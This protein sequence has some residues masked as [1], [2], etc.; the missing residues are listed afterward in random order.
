VIT[1]V[2]GGA[3]SGKSELAERLIL[4]HPGPLVYVAT[5]TAGDADMAARIEAHRQRRDAR[6]AVV[7]A[8]A[9][10]AGA[11]RSAPSRPLLVDAV[12]TWVAAHRDLDQVTGAPL[13]ELEAAL[14]A[15][16][17]PTVLVSDEVGW[18]VHPE[19][20]VGRRFRDVLGEVNQRL[21]AMAED[22]WLVV[23]GRV[24]RLDDPGVLLDGP[25]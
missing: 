25:G 8:G 4:R 24:V 10:L 16:S 5:G 6:F 18:G 22:A 11:L 19:T 1:L 23:A 20:E 2:L 7:E 17:T 12:G 15:R 3:R 14:A 9:D 13:D 21:A